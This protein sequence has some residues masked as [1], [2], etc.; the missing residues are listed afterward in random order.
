MFTLSHYVRS[1]YDP[2]S[3]FD[4]TP[5]DYGGMPYAESLATVLDWPTCRITIEIAH[6]VDGIP[7]GAEIAFPSCREAHELERM[8]EWA[9]TLASDHIA[10]VP[11]NEDIAKITLAAI[12]EDETDDYFGPFARVAR[13]FEGLAH[14]TDARDR[15]WHGYYLEGNGKADAA[16]QVTEGNLLAALGIAKMDRAFLC[17][18]RGELGRA[19]ANVGM[20]WHCALI[21]SS[22]N[23]SHLSDH[24][25]VHRLPKIHG[26]FLA[27]KRHLQ[28]PKQQAK[29][30]VFE[31]WQAWQKAP[32]QYPSVAAFARGMLDK[33]PDTLTS[34]IVIARWV[35]HW[36]TSNS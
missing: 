2:A 12:L 14:H 17:W 4:D 32:G 25:F 10:A 15:P 28:D 33:Q 23:Q 22:L 1:A 8:I 30:F 6:G 21:A 5:I 26:A 16:L 18:E 35:R 9:A 3:K 7:D 29:A 31:C 11:G 27:R 36:A 13:F 19:A 34:E 20:A 24:Y